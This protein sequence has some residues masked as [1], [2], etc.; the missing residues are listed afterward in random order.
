MRRL[1][2]LLSAA[3]VLLAPPA[4]A[5]EIRIKTQDG[6]LLR[7]TYHKAEAGGGRRA[8]LLL[9]MLGRTRA[10][11]APLEK[12][13]NAKG[14]ST[15]AID[16]RGHGESTQKA[17][18]TALNYR[19]FDDRA[20]GE[21]AND[22]VPALAFLQSKGHGKRD[23]TIVGA[24]IGANAA[25]IAASNDLQIHSAVLLS[26]GMDYRG[27]RIQDPAQNWDFTRP[28]YILAS[29]G[30][31]Y[32][33]QSAQT[34]RD[35][36]ASHPNVKVEVFAGLD[37]HGTGLLQEKAGTENRLVAKLAEWVWKN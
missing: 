36:L 11:Y 29:E 26:P 2:P 22:I 34:L 14:I 33:A 20:W 19:A 23:T 28:L 16:F 17:D 3:A 18:G 10:D 21:I 5:D 32:A 7:G 24:S 6:V 25:L 8:A 35:L 31:S 13:L 4:R 1:Y 12:A 9:H 15:F 37:L 30:D 27:V